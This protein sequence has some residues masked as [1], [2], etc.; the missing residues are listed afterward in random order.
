MEMATLFLVKKDVHAMQI[1]L[2]CINKNSL[3]LVKN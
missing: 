3:K 1:R 2:A